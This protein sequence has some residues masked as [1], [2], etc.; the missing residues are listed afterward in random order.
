MLRGGIVATSVLLC[1][2]NEFT[3]HFFSSSF[4]EDDVDKLEKSA[5]KYKCNIILHYVDDIKIMDANNPGDFSWATYYR[6][7]I[8]N[9]LIKYCDRFLY[10]DVDVCV[11]K[12]I[13]QLWDLNLGDACA[14]VIDI[15]VE[16]HFNEHKRLGVQRYFCAGGMFINCKAW[17]KN[18][19]S[20]KA[21]LLLKSGQ[22][23]P[24]YDMDILNIVLDNKVIFI[25]GSWQY[26][27]SISNS[28]DT[29]AM[30]TK[31]FIP[32]NTYIF[33]YT[34]SIKPWHL[35]ARDF[36]VAVPFISAL[37]ESMWSDTTFV[38]PRSYKEWHKF[39]RLSKKE[40]R[41]CDMI[42]YYYKYILKKI[43]QKLSIHV[44]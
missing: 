3:F 17:I 37:K 2:D 9:Y 4:C 18:H 31:V 10:E 14:A 11:L 22:K 32:S 24:Y 35:L 5:Q 6:L 19:V 36:E 42:K 39:A 20:E 8:P 27:Y 25:D 44:S 16:R 1:N 38:E 33:H 15:Q 43:E 12:N 34:G 21:A 29:V 23:F 26:Q 30:P 7:F 28:I 40:R 13:N 41:Y